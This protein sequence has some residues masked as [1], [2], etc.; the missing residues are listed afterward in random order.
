MSAH[1]PGIDADD[2]RLDIARTLYKNPDWLITLCDGSGRVL[3]R[4][5]RRPKEDAAQKTS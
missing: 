4:S 2:K 5:Q 1:T 3:A